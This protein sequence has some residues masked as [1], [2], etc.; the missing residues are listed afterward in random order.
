M[1]SFCTHGQNWHIKKSLYKGLLMFIELFTLGVSFAIINYICLSF[2]QIHATFYFN[3]IN[4][5]GLLIFCCQNV[6]AKISLSETF[7]VLFVISFHFLI[8]SNFPYIHQR[9]LHL[10]I[11]L[12]NYYIWDYYNSLA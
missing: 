11:Y 10:S 7:R 2:M 9:F 4:Y 6:A 1:Y 8:S 12:H 3:Y 5:S